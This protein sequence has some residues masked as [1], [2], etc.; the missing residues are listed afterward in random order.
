MVVLVASG[1][2]KVFSPHQSIFLLPVW[3]YYLA[4]VVELF[5]AG[6]L[7]TGG[8]LRAAQGVIVMAFGGVMYAL[9]RPSGDCGCFGGIVPSGRLGGLIASGGFG[10][11]AS[12][13]LGGISDKKE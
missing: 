9:F 7:L 1:V 2:A 12:F 8:R 3:A 11:L 4:S 5:L 6:M 13:Y 10:A